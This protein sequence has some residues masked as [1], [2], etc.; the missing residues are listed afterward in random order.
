[1]MRDALSGAVRLAYPDVVIT[2]ADNYP[3]AWA[4]AGAKPDLILCDL[5][6]PGA[7]PEAGIAGLQRTAPGVPLLVFTGHEDDALLLRLF[8][9]GVSGLLPKSARSAVVESAIQLVLAGG[10]YIPR[11]LVDMADGV[12]AG[13]VGDLSAVHLSPRQTEILRAI[14]M[15]RTNKEI[16]RTFELSPATVKAHA[17]AAFLALGVTNRTEAAFKARQRGLI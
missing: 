6:M 12:G 10:R 16:A 3:S 7:E 15:G 2:E 1:M 17:A 4:A 5:I 11:R 8:Q 9:M 13:P 14:A